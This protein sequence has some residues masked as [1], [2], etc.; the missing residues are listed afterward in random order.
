MPWIQAFGLKMSYTKDDILAQIKAAEDL[1]INGFLFW[2]AANKYGVV[3]EALVERYKL[4][5]KP[6]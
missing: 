5:E 4:S 6:K 2:N 3:R 1:G